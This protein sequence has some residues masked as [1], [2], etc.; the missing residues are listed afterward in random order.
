VKPRGYDREACAYRARGGRR[1]P[2]CTHLD[3]PMAQSFLLAYE[4]TRGKS[5]CLGC[6]HRR[7]GQRSYLDV[8]REE[9]DG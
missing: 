5:R 1:G 6:M 3:V 7:A 4:V 2:V 9:T 8:R